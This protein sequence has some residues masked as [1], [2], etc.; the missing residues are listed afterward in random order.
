MA[1]KPEERARAEIGRL[2]AAAGWSVQSMSEA[3]IHAARS[4]A[5]RGF[6]PEIRRGL[7]AGLKL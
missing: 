2:L 1:D 3:N 6:P 4:V 7:I 5:I